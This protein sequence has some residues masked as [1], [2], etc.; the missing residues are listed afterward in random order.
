MGDA[1]WAQRQRARRLREWAIQGTLGL[2]LVALLIGFAQNISA[3]LAAR[4]IKSGFGFLFDRA[5]FNIGELLFDYSASDSY[6]R[7]FAVGMANTLRVSLAGIVL[8]SVLGVVIGVM[9]PVAPRAGGVDRRCVRRGLPQHAAA[10]SIARDL[11]AG[12]RT[13]A[14]CVQPDRGRRRGAA[15]EAGAADRGAG[16]RDARPR[17]RCDRGTRRRRRGQG[18]G[19]ALVDG[20]L[21][22]RRARR[23]LPRVRRRVAAGRCVRWLVEAGRRRPW[24]SSAARR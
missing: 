15:V 9:R 7:A 1:A 24:R 20:R 22:A 5:G 8:A 17:M 16:T 3:N 11:P 6:L 19:Q 4:Q 14:G 23:W 10:D 21:G 12:D 13:P 2:V 18:R